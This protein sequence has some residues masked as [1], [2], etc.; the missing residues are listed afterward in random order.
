MNIT[1]PFDSYRQPLHRLVWLT[2]GISH[3]T[4]G[5]PGI[6]IRMATGSLEWL[7]AYQSLFYLNIHNGNI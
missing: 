7:L 2:S 6:L 4:R 5:N 1:T 3:G